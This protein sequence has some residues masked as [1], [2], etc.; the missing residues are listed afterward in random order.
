MPVQNGLKVIQF[1]RVILGSCAKLR[2]FRNLPSRAR[3]LTYKVG[4]NDKVPFTA[5]SSSLTVH[6][7][8]KLSSFKGRRCAAAAFEMLGLFTD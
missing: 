2:S 7:R 3:M 5:P 1:I 6:S 8:P 4:N